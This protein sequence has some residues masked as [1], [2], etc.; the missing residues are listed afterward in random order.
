MMEMLGLHIVAEFHGVS[1]EKLDDLFFL[2]EV[3]ISAAKSAG[4]RILGY[5]F[6][7]FSP[8]GVTGIVAI[9]ESHLSI[10]T[11]PEFGY[12]AFDVFSC[13]RVNA[14]KI[15]EEVL[16]ALNPERVVFREIARGKEYTDERTI[17]YET[18]EEEKELL[19]FRQTSSPQVRP[20][21]R[22]L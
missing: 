5:K 6:H 20:S 21:S 12:A 8:H 11:W 19:L 10:H 3:L 17:D 9:S 2:E 15:F 18:D 7:K 14:R 13:R 1:K 4:A 16:K 22:V